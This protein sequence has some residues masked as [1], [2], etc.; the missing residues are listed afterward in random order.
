MWAT[1]APVLWH[2]H[3]SASSAARPA[4]GCPTFLMTGSD[5]EFIKALAARLV[6]SERVTYIHSYGP[7]ERWL[8]VDASRVL[9]LSL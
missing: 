2:G 5:V 6:L 8:T 3:L 7:L 9:Y 4:N 1:A